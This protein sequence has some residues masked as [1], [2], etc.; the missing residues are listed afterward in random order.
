MEKQV[1]SPELKPLSASRVKTMENCSWLYW[2]NYH[3]K[4][5]QEKN[6]GAKKGDICHDIFELLLKKNRKSYFKKMIA[7]D[8]VTACPSIERLIKLYIKRAEL[9]DTTEGFLHIDQMILVGLKT[10]FY[11]KGGVLVAPEFK[12]DITSKEP[13][14][15]IK[16]FM[17]KPF[18]KGQEVIIDDFKS[19]KRKFAGEDA[20]SNLQALFYSF[21]AT[22]L[23]PDKTPTVRFIFLQH[24][25][26]PLVTIKFSEDALLGFKYY[27]A[28]TQSKVDGFNES[29]SKSHFAFDDPKPT[30]GSF[31]GSNLCGFA[32]HPGKLKKDGT[33]MWHCPYRFGYDYYAALDKHGKVMRCAFKREDLKVKDGETVEKRHYHGCPKHINPLDEF[34][35]TPTVAPEPRKKYANVLDDLF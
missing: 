2:C 16:G 27:L 24:P 32:S 30:D 34:Q 20:E 13:V 10:D 1:P 31:G 3:L 15:R 8:S 22:Q 6:E 4:L 29:V 5:P 23:W 14:F 12:F 26:K 25:E 7:A 17:D 35:A 18:I 33:K 11:V 28:A 21:A 9:H 19:S